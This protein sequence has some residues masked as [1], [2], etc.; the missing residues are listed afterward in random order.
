MWGSPPARTQ[1][2]GCREKGRGTKGCED[3]R[4]KTLQEDRVMDLKKRRGNLGEIWRRT[5]FG[6]KILSQFKS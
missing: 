4:E 1:E 3:H 2:S 6:S 5:R